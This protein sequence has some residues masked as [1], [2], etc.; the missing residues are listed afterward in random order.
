MRAASYLGLRPIRQPAD[1]MGHAQLKKVLTQTEEVPNMVSR[2]PDTETP[3]GGVEVANHFA[4]GP[5]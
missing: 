3:L 2:V 4:E 1:I 5:A